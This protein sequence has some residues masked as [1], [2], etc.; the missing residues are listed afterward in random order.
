MDDRVR[1]EVFEVDK[2]GF[3][4]GLGRDADVSEY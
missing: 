1:V 2:D 4:F 3:E